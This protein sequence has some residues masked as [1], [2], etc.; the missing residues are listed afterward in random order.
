MLELFKRWKSKDT[1]KTPRVL[2]REHL[3]KVCVN[4]DAER[5][6][7]FNSFTDIYSLVCFVNDD[8]PAEKQTVHASEAISDFMF[9]V[10]HT[11]DSITWNER[12]KLVGRRE[13][14]ITYR[15]PA[16]HMQNLY[17]EHVNTIRAG[18]R[19]PI[20]TVSILTHDGVAYPVAFCLGFL[21]GSQTDVYKQY[22]SSRI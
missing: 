17:V 6:A 18:K 12:K 8:F 4:H 9:V 14:V 13:N 1:V 15:I 19:S 10:G 3:S 11:Q 5:D 2:M 16:D 22:P 20:R 21:W 7:A